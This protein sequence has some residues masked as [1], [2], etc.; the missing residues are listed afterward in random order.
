MEW[1]SEIDDSIRGERSFEILVVVNSTDTDAVDTRPVANE[2]NQASETSSP[3]SAGNGGL[4]GFQ[5]T[6]IGIAV[7]MGGTTLT[8]G[9]FALNRNQ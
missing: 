4:S 7:G 5:L 2:T 1:L 6:L 8:I 9:L 3:G